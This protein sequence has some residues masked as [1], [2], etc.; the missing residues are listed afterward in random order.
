MRIRTALVVMSLATLSGAQIDSVTQSLM[1]PKAT[2]TQAYQPWGTLM[3]GSNSRFQHAGRHLIDSYDQWCQAWPY[4][5]GDNYAPG[6]RIPTMIDW[7]REQIL[8]ISL[9]DLGVSGYGIYV[10][11]VQQSSGYSYDVRYVMT[12][13]SMQVGASFS[14]GEGT[15]PYVVLRIARGLGIPNYYSRWYTPSNTVWNRGC[16]CGHCHSHNN[17]V[18]MVGAGGVLLPYV[19]PGQS[20]EDRKKK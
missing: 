16:C 12:R 4:I 8:I 20:E 17:T 5:A 3:V 15:S 19:P 11:N 7:R 6:M 9:G 10:E 2:E 18:W 1:F 13:P 14:Y